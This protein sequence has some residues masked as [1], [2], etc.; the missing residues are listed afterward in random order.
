MQGEAE[1]RNIDLN[2]NGGG[3][4]FGRRGLIEERVREMVAMTYFQSTSPIPLLQGRFFLAHVGQ[5]TYT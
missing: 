2:K 4:P 3:A 5:H 1:G